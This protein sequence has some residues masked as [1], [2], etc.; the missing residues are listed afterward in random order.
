MIDYHK[1]HARYAAAGWHRRFLR[2]AYSR[3]QRA[4]ESAGC[5]PL[6]APG[7]R[8]LLCG[9]GAP[10]TAEEFA[11][12]VYERQPSAQLC[13]IDIARAPLAALRDATKAKLVCSDAR[14]L[15]FADATFDLV[16]TDFLLQFFDREE[17]RKVLAEWARVL[18]PGGALTTRDW[19]TRGRGL[20]PLWDAL[21][22]GVL[23]A[24]LDVRVHVLR[25]DDLREALENAGFD[26]TVARLGR[27]PLIHLVAGVLRRSNAATITCGTSRGCKTSTGAPP[28]AAH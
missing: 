10:A 3:S 25:D 17:R 18:R 21:R 6:V 20:D 16:E 7:A 24:V 12:F 28:P 27:W 26:A 15:P 2:I 19:V 9:A 5:R 22:R 23:R 11:A 8:V 4:L 1:R 14:A 13:V